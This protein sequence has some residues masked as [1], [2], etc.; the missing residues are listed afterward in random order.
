MTKITDLSYFQ[1][2]L[3]ATVGSTIEVF[4]QHPLNIIKNNS[5]YG[6]K[7]TFNI[8][9]LYRGTFL[10]AGSMSAITAVQ[11][12]AYSFLYNNLNINSFNASL[13]AGAC[14]SVITT[15][16]ELGV[17]QKTKMPHLKTSEIFKLQQQKYGTKFIFRGF[18][19]C[20]MRESVFTS[21]LLYLTP[22]IEKKLPFGNDT[23]KSLY[24]SCISGIVSGIITHPFDTIKAN[25]QFYLYDKIN[26]EKL[27]KIKNIYRGLLCRTFRLTTTFFIMNQ[28]N[29]FFIQYL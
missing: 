1:T 15:P 13:L 4:L 6:M 20:C 18:A 25:Q 24:A 9:E 16:F 22:L 3:L 11:F 29:K 10:N 19:S 14:S 23:Q 12:S 7:T 28:S 26:Y 8:R 2:S 5:Q 17:I 27:F 21:G